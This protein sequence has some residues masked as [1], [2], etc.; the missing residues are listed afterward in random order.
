LLGL[1]RYKGAQID[2]W[3]GDIT[4]FAVD[5]MTNAAQESLV[6]GFG[7]D[8]AIHRVG[9]PDILRECQKIGTCPTGSAVVTGA[10][11]LPARFV[12][13]AVGPIWSGGHKGE[14]ALLSSCYESVFDAF[15]GLS[16]RHLSIPAIST[17][18]F[19]FPA[20]LAAEIAFT[21][22]K[23]RLE[24]AQISQQ[25]RFTFVA[26]DDSMYD[27]LQRRLFMEFADELDADGF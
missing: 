23:A 5:A 21:T 26:F 11:Q 17:G 13:H 6:G 18:A 24:A 20:E 3:Q 19:G 9:G 10:G 2:V 8:G 12:I 15:A 27:V 25:L 14:R 7:V 16:I 4:T 1:R 22:L